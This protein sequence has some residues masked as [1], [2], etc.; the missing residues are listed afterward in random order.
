M[1]LSLVIGAD[2]VPTASNYGLFSEGAV[3]VLFGEE[4]LRVLSDC[5]FKIF[6][7]ETPLTD[8]PSP[9]LKHGPCLI[10]PV[11]TIKGISAIAPSLLTLANNHILDQ[12]VQGLKST[13]ELLESQHIGHIGAGADLKAASKSCVF[14][15]D[16]LKIGIYA[17][18]EHEFSIATDIS[19]G[20]NPFDPLFCL[21]HIADLKEQCDFV[22]VLYHGGKEHY[23]YPSP[24][25]QKACRRMAHKGADLIICQHSHCVGSYESYD[26]ATIIYGQGNFIFDGSNNEC[27]NTGLLIR[28][29]FNDHMELEYIPVVR[30]GNT[31]RLAT[32]ETAKDILSAYENRSRDI[33]IPGVVEQKY[34]QLAEEKK[35]NYVRTLRG[36]GK[37]TGKIDDRFFKGQLSKRLCTPEYML[38]ITNYTECEA[39]QELMLKGFRLGKREY[40]S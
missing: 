32:G 27:W 12:N 33:Q 2:L 29:V 4:L 36:M 6:N 7:L 40:K 26:D 8:V 17:C 23:R 38:A 5:D 11:S 9:I 14:E 37:L 22:I 21:D 13:I 15:K 16:A 30:K 31:V 10:A 25:L 18:A 19:P 24:W 34:E 28:A 1:S 39:H 35:I 3:D 20:A